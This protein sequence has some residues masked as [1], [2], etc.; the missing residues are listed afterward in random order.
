M[1]D[2]GAATSG[3]GPAHSNFQDTILSEME[4]FSSKEE[5]IP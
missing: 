1:Q 2:Q 5:R 3:Y 4:M